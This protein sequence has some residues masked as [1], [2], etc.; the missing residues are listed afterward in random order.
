MLVSLNSLPLCRCSLHPGSGI[1]ID[2]YL[3]VSVR[4]VR[5]SFDWLREGLERLELPVILSAAPLREVPDVDDQEPPPLRPGQAA[6][7][8]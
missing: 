3:S 7:P 1:Y 5:E 6:L 4:K 2:G 8:E